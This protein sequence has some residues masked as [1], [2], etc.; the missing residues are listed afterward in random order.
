MKGASHPDERRVPQPVV[1]TN[2]S[3]T[4]I[5]RRSHGPPT[6]PARRHQRSGPGF[7][8]RPDAGR[9]AAN[10]RGRA[11]RRRAWA[12]PASASKVCP[13]ARTST[14]GFGRGRRAAGARWLHRAAVRGMGRPD[15]AG[16]YAVHRRRQRDRR[17]S[18]RSS[19][20]NTTTACISSRSTGRPTARP[21]AASAG[22]LLREQRVHARGSAVRRTARWVPGYTH[23][24]DAQVAGSAW[25][26]D[27]RGASQG[28]ASGAVKRNSQIGT[29]H[30]REYA[31]SMRRGRLP[32]TR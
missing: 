19:S 8:R 24:E 6:V 14:R 7:G 11:G 9:P 30:H 13:P 25:R 21:D 22:V 31:V 12:F 3:R 23:G 29:P 5:H 1:R 26:L 28:A 27:R 17:S 18:R 15:H 2:R 4:S 10:G 32:A 16:R 20:A